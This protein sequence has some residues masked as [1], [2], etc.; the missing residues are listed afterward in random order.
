MGTSMFWK[1]CNRKWTLALWVQS[2]RQNAINM[3]AAKSRSHQLKAKVEEQ[4]S[5]KQFFREITRAFCFDFL[6]VK[7]WKHLVLR[8]WA[9]ALAE[10]QEASSE[11]PFLP[12]HS[13]H[14]TGQFCENFYGKLLESHTKFLMRLHLLPFV[15]SSLKNISKQHQFSAV[16]TVRKTALK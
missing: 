8:K 15:Y 10:N 3:M 16:N 6:E 14:Q 9:K 12:A 11:R 13:S 4:K 2:W 7:E 5:Q 1:N